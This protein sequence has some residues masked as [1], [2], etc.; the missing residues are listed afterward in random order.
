MRV[1]QPQG[2][3]QVPRDQGG[4]REPQLKKMQRTGWGHEHR[5]APTHQELPQVHLKTSGDTS[6]CRPAVIFSLSRV[7]FGNV[8][9]PEGKGDTDMA[10]A[11]EA[12]AKLW[13]H[14]STKTRPR[15]DP[16]EH[17]DPVLISCSG[18]NSPLYSFWVL[19][20]SIKKKYIT[21]GTNTELHFQ[22][23]RCE[24]TSEQHHTPYPAR[25]SH[26]DL[27]IAFF[28]T[29]SKPKYLPGEWEALQTHRVCVWSPQLVLLGTQKADRMCFPIWIHEGSAACQGR[30]LPYLPGKQLSTSGI[31]LGRCLLIRAPSF[32]AFAG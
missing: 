32:F 25:P 28:P 4:N 13:H 22:Q 30:E 14:C 12:T 27:A 16:W 11:E 10:T 1:Q 17:T 20:Y 3:S 9:T 18:V 15:G 21:K 19:G 8:G 23:Q 2:S 24:H 26:L 31:R 6:Q 29:L 5:S 7:I